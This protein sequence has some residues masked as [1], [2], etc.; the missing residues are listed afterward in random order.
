[1]TLISRNIIIDTQYFLSKALDFESAELQSLADLVKKGLARVYLTDITEREIRK[2]IQ[3]ELSK[4]HAKV[5]ASDARYLKKIPLF[6]KFLETYSEGKLVSYFE[7]K[8]EA[9]KK[10]CAVNIIPSNTVNLLSIFEDYCR[11][12][13][14]FNIATNKKHEFPDAF[15]LA[16]ISNWA[17]QTDQRAYL[18]SG[19]KDWEL[20][21]QSKPLQYSFSEE[22]HFSHIEEL[23]SF[24]DLVL[25]TEDALKDVISFADNIIEAKSGELRTR[26]LMELENVSFESDSDEEIEIVNHYVLVCELLNKE[27]VTVDR[28]GAT[29]SLDFKLTG[30]F[31]YGFYSF[32][33][34]AY[35]L[36]TKS[37]VGEKWVNMAKRQE[38][39]ETFEVE[40]TYK[41]GLESNAELKTPDMPDSIAMSPDEGELLNLDEW[42][43]TLPVIVCGVKDGKI[44]DDGSGTMEF[45]NFYE[46]V[47]TF[48]TLN[49]YKQN[50]EFTKAL[51]NRVDEPLRFETW[52]AFELYSSD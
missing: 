10:N 45:D 28:D 17:D 29:Y 39:Y 31:T 36:D 4:A 8:F 40:I 52:K 33:D 13:T 38:F 24:T 23:S 1:M 35:D 11:D 46:A 25:R 32:E 14:P 51:G 15:A 6:K 41:D 5:Q 7:N 27:I 42:A 20:Y 3:D 12:K 18:L 21:V 37:Y 22:L 47:K 19:D 50:C 34:A 2:K 16:A 48:P 9:F 49:I 43:L 26:I 30:I 44:T